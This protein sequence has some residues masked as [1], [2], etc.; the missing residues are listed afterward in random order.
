MSAWLPA[1]GRHLSRVQRL[2]D[3]TQG[4]VVAGGGVIAGGSTLEPTL[5]QGPVRS[6]FPQIGTPPGA[7]TCRGR[8]SAACR[9]MTLPATEQPV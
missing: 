3:S 6:R 2:L 9:R 7:A 4:T 1:A 5:V 8:R